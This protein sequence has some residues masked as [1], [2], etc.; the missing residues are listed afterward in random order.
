MLNSDSI[1]EKL[2]DEEDARAC[3]DISD[4]A[5]RE[6]PQNFVSIL[7]AQ[8]LTK[9]GDA[10][11][12]PKTVLAWVMA[13]VQAPVVLTG[14]LVPIRESG[15]LLPQ[16][17]IASW[18]RRFP[19]RKWF[20]VGGSI[21]QAASVA[22]IGLAAFYLRGVAAGLVIIGLLIVFS[23]A[24]GFCSVA[25]KDVVGK[26]IPKRRRGRLT[27]WSASAAGFASVLVGV[28]LLLPAAGA[29][30]GN[31]AELAW[32][33]FAAGVLWFLGA[34]TFGRVS[35]FRGETDGGRNAFAEGIER[36]NLLVRDRPFRLFV[37]ARAL[38]LCSALSAPYYVLLARELSGTSASTLG[39][40][41]VAA[42]L[43]SLVAA[44]IWG[45][46]A[47]RSSRRVI[48]AAA[49]ASG[50]VGIVVFAVAEFLTPV[51]EH[52]LFFPAAY[53]VLSVAHDGVRVGRKTYVVDLASGN[54]RTDYVSVSNTVIGVVLLIAGLS[55]ALS[56][57]VSLTGIVLLLSIFGLSGAWLAT[58]LKEVT[59]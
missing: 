6:T 20:W 9:L 39:L 52:A 13:T 10:I 37:I 12:S 18:V 2:V 1:Y 26:T 54:K 38:L 4:D 11:A 3:E 30:A 56:S 17:V 24:R 29:G 44:P 41:V 31:D 51:A 33:L 23:L 28:V 36:L 32:L 15:S 49:I 7:T 46:F 21:V 43:A 19:V 25:S 8:L 16:L 34:L 27:G 5:C 55:G 59:Q 42:G 53:F 58:R 40:F 14:L 47:D 45:R 22:S 35:E 50:G 57:V 48:V